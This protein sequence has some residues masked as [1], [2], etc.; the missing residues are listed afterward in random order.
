MFARQRSIFSALLV[1]ALTFALSFSGA[2]LGVTPAQAGTMTNQAYVGWIGGS[3]GSFAGNVDCATGSVLTGIRS[4]TSGNSVFLGIECREILSTGDLG[5][6]TRTSGS[7]GV[8]HQ[9]P[10]GTA[11][12]G[13]FVKTSNSPQNVGV[14]C[15][16]PPNKLDAIQDVGPSSGSIVRDVNCADN[17]FVNRTYLHSGAWFD[18]FMV[19]CS[20]LAGYPS[21]VVV[22][23]TG[24]P[25]GAASPG[26]VLTNATT[27][28]GLPTPTLAYTWERSTSL[29]GPWDVVV[30][31]T[32]STYTLQIA[33]LGYYFRT[34]VTGSNLVNS[35]PTSATTTSGETGLVQLAT[36]A[37][38]N[39]Q[40]AS[41]TGT[42]TA[43]NQTSD[44]T[45][46][47]D[48]TGLTAGGSLTVT[49][50]RST[51][52]SLIRTCTLTE[53]QVTSTS[54]SCTFPTLSD[55]DWSVTASQSSSTFQS[56]SSAA[57]NLKVDTQAPTVNSIAITPDLAVDKKVRV[58]L[59][60]SESIDV[61]DS[62]KI[63]L[64][65]TGTWTKSNPT[66]SGNTYSFDVVYT[67][68]INDD[69][70]VA[71]G[72]AAVTDIAGNAQTAARTFFEQVNTVNPSASYAVAP[73][74]LGSGSTSTSLTL[75]FTR[76]VWG[77]TSADFSWP[78]T[79]GASC[80]LSSVTPSSGPASSYTLAATCTGAG[81][82]TLRLAANAVKD[83]ASVAGPAA[84]LDLTVI[85]DTTAPTIT[86]I[87][88]KV[89][90]SRV[91]YSVT[92]SE[93][94]SQFPASAISTAGA[95]T[96]TPTS[97]LIGLN[98]SES[99]VVSGHLK[100]KPVSLSV[101]AS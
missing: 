98:T 21:A 1:A 87:S 53:A 82:S 50:T 27:F 49:A 32:S 3:G 78:A 61:V 88:G 60:F 16:T 97:S 86:A 36:P 83:F 31:A 68:L 76:P 41:D 15:Q 38:P 28:L 23:N 35:L 11:A 81:T 33:D 19:G 12:V 52:T 96:E 75:T 69:I 8:F 10:T 70:T 66:V 101:H 100:T 14:H 18:G 13:L 80:S 45:P 73:A 95:T 79:N 20:L 40:T 34:V 22:G 91:D 47:F 37:Q 25:T 42:A 2:I 72:V 65:S 84:A 57:L 92:F 99:F 46:T 58:T 26:S 71:V 43:D 54:A 63:L 55:G 93:E 89:V 59:S 24:A 4:A 62:T 7:G 64:G 17:G 44:N 56:A 29:S 30:G 67:T 90:A 94:L 6:V 48:L 39:L 74:R 9:C 77:L 51:P 85:R 5:A